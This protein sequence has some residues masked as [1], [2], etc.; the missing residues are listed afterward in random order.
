MKVYVD[1]HDRRWG[2]YKIDFEKI[3]NAIKENENMTSKTYRIQ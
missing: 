3:A 1:I 2:K